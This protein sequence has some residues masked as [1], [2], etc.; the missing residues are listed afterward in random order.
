MPRPKAQYSLVVKN[1]FSGKQLKVEMIDLPYMG[2]MRRFRLR[3]NGQWA[4]RVPVASKTMVLRQ[5]RSW[6]VKH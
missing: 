1:H 6:L 5:V 3:V 4:R 2:E